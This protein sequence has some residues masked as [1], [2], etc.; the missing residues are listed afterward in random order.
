MGVATAGDGADSGVPSAADDA[1]ADG[2][3]AAREA[4]GAAGVGGADK[5]AWDVSK[6]AG[7]A[8]NG[9]AGAVETA[10][11]AGAGNEEGTADGAVPDEVGTKAVAAGARYAGGAGPHASW[12]GGGADGV[13]GTGAPAAAFAVALPATTTM[14]EGMTRSGPDPGGTSEGRG[15]DESAAVSGGR[16][17]VDG[18]VSVGGGPT[19][20]LVLPNRA[21][22]AFSAS[23]RTGSAAAGSEAAGAGRG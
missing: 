16:T 6:G 10:A 21:L 22:A 13:G 17:L 14:R 1:G 20:I 2:A 8:D 9:G 18:G 11:G 5:G 15:E 23:E 12:V 19:P 4:S 3:S 7:G